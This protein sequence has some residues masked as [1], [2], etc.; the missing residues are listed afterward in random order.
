M[1]YTYDKDTT[2]KLE[3]TNKVTT[4]N[5]HFQGKAIINSAPR[6]MTTVTPYALEF[7]GHL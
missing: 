6:C 5:H 3:D 7:C 1:D 2:S 4:L